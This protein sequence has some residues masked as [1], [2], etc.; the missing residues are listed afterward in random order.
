MAESMERMWWTYVNNASLFIRRITETLLDEKSLLVH[1]S[2]RVPWYDTMKLLVEQSIRA[3]THARQLKYKIETELGDAE[4]GKYLFD[5]YCGENLKMKYRPAWGYARFLAENDS[6]TLKETYLWLKLDDRARALDWIKFVD[7][8]QQCLD[9]G[10]GGVFLLEVNDESLLSSGSRFETLSYD[11]TISEYDRFMFNMLAASN[12]RLSGSLRKQYL[13]EL[14]SNVA[15]NDI[16]LSV[17]CMRRGERF[18]KNP[19]KVLRS[20]VEEERRSD[21]AR[22]SL[23]CKADDIEQ[24]EWTTQIKLLFP[25]MEN[26]RRKLIERHHA[27]IAKCLPSSS[28]WGDQIDEPKEADIGFLYHN[29]H[30]WALTSDEYERLKM[31]RDVRNSLAHMKPLTSDELQKIFNES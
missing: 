8:Y 16:E 7:Q 30:R 3:E 28:G 25:L 14:A 2:A 24:G 18:I 4:P 17:E 31:Y 23:E 21:G 15:G 10:A 19:L 11:K 5:K 6:N 20:I 12:V 26:F 27:E 1:M 29:A 22:Y 9:G 13:A